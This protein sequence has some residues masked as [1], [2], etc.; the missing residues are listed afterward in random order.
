MTTVHLCRTKQLT[1]CVPT[2]CLIQSSPQAQPVDV[3]AFVPWV[4]PSGGK[5][6][7]HG[8]SIDPA[9]EFPVQK[10]E[11][12]NSGQCLEVCSLAHC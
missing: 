10:V 2:H 11:Q 9:T 7:L 3:Q 4:F 1:Q 12:R 5:G 8:N 6:W